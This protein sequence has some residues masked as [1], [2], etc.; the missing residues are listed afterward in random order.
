[1]TDGLLVESAKDHSARGDRSRPS[2]ERVPV[3]AAWRDDREMEAYS[4]RARSRRAVAEASWCTVVRWVVLCL[5]R[6]RF[7]CHWL[8]LRLATSQPDVPERS[9]GDPAGFRAFEHMG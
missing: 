5:M 2:S 6:R 8:R 3:A 1:M 4:A 7:V 9:D